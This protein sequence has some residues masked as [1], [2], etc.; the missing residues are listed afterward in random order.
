MDHTGRSIANSNPSNVTDFS[1]R[2]WFKATKSGQDYTSKMHISALTGLPTITVATPIFK[3]NEF[4][5]AMSAGIRHK[6]GSMLPCIMQG[7]FYINIF[8][9]YIQ[10]LQNLQNLRVIRGDG[11]AGFPDTYGTKVYRNDVKGGIA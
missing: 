9:L 7:S 4:I 6:V 5:G 2:D 8:S 11:V 10:R 3:D 1:F